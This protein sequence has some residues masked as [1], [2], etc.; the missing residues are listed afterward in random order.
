MTDAAEDGTSS[1]AQ[2]TV[3][4]P[5]FDN[6]DADLIIRTLDHVD[7][8]VY[9]IIL[10]HAS[11]VFA[12][13]AA[14]PTAPDTDSRVVEVT[15]S[16]VVWDCILRICYPTVLPA[17]V[18][19]QLWPLL[20]AAKKYDMACVRNTVVKEMSTPRMLEQETLRVYMLACSYGF[21]DV[22]AAA[23][24]VSLRQTPEAR[25]SVPELRS[26]TSAAYFNLLQY[27]QECVKAAISIA[28]DERFLRNHRWDGMVS[29]E[30]PD[31]IV[32]RSGPGPGVPEQHHHADC[33][34]GTAYVTNYTSYRST[35]DD[36]MA[37]STER[38]KAHPHGDAVLDP[39]LIATTAQA[40][41]LCSIC[42]KDSDASEISHF[43]KFHAAQIDA[44][45]AKVVL[46]VES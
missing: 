36:Y 38:L 6:P 3:A 1:A 10:T 12:D 28:E 39:V 22:A 34:Q 27:R 15:E 20:E 30:V 29:E 32:R 14:L 37:Q 4:S 25:S 2:V 21:N 26:A 19:D 44:A 42:R 24:R 8:H 43:I 41:A 5:P 31:W 33:A 45:I 11:S 18:S 46:V 23:A 17:I 16:S 40:A 9:K 13:M 35:F 7:F